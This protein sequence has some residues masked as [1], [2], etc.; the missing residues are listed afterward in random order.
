MTSISRWRPISSSWIS[1]RWVFK[2]KEDG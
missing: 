2:E 1:E